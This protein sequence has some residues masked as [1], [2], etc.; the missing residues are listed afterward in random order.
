[1]NKVSEYFDKSANK[2]NLRGESNPKE[3]RKKVTEGSSKTN[4]ADDSIDDDVFQPTNST[5]D[6]S[7]VLVSLF[8]KTRSKSSWDIYLLQ[9]NKIYAN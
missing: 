2:R 4:N 3:E 6:I 5:S 7:E 1:M 8:K 9:W